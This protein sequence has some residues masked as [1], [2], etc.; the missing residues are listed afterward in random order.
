M[1]SSQNFLATRALA[2]SLQEKGITLVP[3][4]N[5]ILFDLVNNV[6]LANVFNSGNVDQSIDDY[7]NNLSLDISVISDNPENLYNNLFYSS[8][9]SLTKVVTGHI[10]IAKNDI[11][12]LVVDF[13]QKIQEFL[14]RNKV[15]DPSCELEIISLTPSDALDYNPLL[16]DL[17]AFKGTSIETSKNILRFFPRTN[18]ELMSM[19]VTG[20][21][22]LDIMNLEWLTKK[23]TDFL[24]NIWNEYFVKGEKYIFDN[25]TNENVFDKADISL[26]MYL[27]SL[28]LY[29]N[30]SEEN[31]VSLTEYQ[32]AIADLRTFSGTVL[33]NSVNMI[34]MSNNSETLIIENNFY[35]KSIKVNGYVY[36]KWL[37]EG[38]DNSILLGLLISKENVKNLN[39]ITQMSEKLK[40]SWNQYCSLY[41]I[42]K[43][44]NL[45]NE[46]KSYLAN[47]LQFSLSDKIQLEKDYESTNGSCYE[48]IIKLV[49]DELSELNLSDID[50][51]YKVSLLLIA[52]CRFHYTNSYEI[53]NDINEAG[54]VNPD[55]SPRDA[56]TIATVY[57][58]LDY[59]LEQMVVS[60]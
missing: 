12:P 26:V 1:I 44:N 16:N 49:N 50:N 27:F 60:K 38:G 58:L 21:K 41:K 17:K 32:S 33:I 43:K 5:S 13:A 54:L 36:K 39:L 3:K 6:S 48:T 14:E 55:L 20:D 40:N 47:S 53:L 52:K 15:V 57:Y 30:P 7:L 10:S 35:K 2:E 24:V 37:S 9:E 22:Q 42:N 4:P 18:E 29:N 46:F 59:F 28:Y 56:A 25:L 19:F 8:I 31:K 51:P 45:L 11:K 34:N 23:P